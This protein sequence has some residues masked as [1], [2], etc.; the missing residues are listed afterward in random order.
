MNTPLR[1]VGIAMLAMIVLVLAHATYIQV[2]KADEYRADQ[3]NQRVLLDEYSRERGQIVSQFDGQV[4]AHGEP[5][6]GRLQYLR[7]YSE[8]PM[9]APVTGYYSWRYG[10]AG[11]ER[12]RNDI[13]SG[14][15][16][17]LFV[18]RL[19]DMITGRDPRGGHVQVTI[20]PNVQRTAYETMTDRDFTGAVVALKPDTGEILG[21][22][23]TPSYDPNA[24]ATHDGEAQEEAWTAMS[25]DPSKPMSNRAIRE[26]YAPGSTFKLVTTAAALE[27][28]ATPDTEVT[29]AS[30]ITLPNT[31]TQLQNFGGQTCPGS[32]LEDALAYSCNTAFAELA[33]ELGASTLRS[34]AENFG[35]GKSDLDIPMRVAMSSVGQLSDEASLY[36]SGIGQ[37]DVR[38]TPLQVAQLAA[39]VANDGTAMR[40]QLVKSLLAPDLST[41][42]DYSDDELTGEPALSEENAEILRDMMIESEENTAGGGKR[43]D[44]T[45]ASKTGTAEHGADPK[46]T[47]PHAW[48]TAFAPADD[49]EVAVAVL[50]ESGGDRG[51]AATGGS[52]AA[53]IGRM[54]IDSALRGQSE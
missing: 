30:S 39:T 18:R 47:P 41:I 22:V 16:A 46:N 50:V 23:S 54:T 2:F 26:T 31:Q 44:L 12:A 6:S 4:L 48:Y 7:R 43:D 52:V 5:T 45:I 3:R 38:L 13:L 25:E 21:M 49:P 1:R 8:G 40:P 17:R 15:D 28:G 36:Q 20:D 24:L 34:T 42:S 33:G 35:I 29:S 11:L 10:S 14:N 51:L 19:S 53:E 32:T 9:Y 37:R 27:D